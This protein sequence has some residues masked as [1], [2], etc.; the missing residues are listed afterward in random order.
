[1]QMRG[2]VAVRVGMHGSI[3][4]NVRVAMRS[5]PQAVHKAPGQVD[6]SKTNQQPARNATACGLDSL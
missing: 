1:M 5:A 3:G 4:M 2:I 6:N